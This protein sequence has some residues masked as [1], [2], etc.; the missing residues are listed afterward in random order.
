VK[1]DIP[2]IFFST[3]EHDQYHKPSDQVELIDGE[4]AARVAKLVFLL[5]AKV[6]T[7]AVDPAWLPGSLEQ[8]RAIIAESEGN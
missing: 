1:L 3:G 4:K 6:A 5:G 8:V 2:A 7:G